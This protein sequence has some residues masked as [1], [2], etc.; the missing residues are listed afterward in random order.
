MLPL[1]FEAPSDESL[2]KIIITKEFIDG[3]KPILIKGSA[4]KEG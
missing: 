2:Q 3:E 1:E 4:Q